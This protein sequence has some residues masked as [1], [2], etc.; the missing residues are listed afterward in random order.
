MKRIIQYFAAALITIY[1]TAAQADYT[2]IVPQKPGGGTSVWATII[3]RELEKHLGEKIIIQH[4]PGAKDIPGIE[5]FHKELR[6]DPKTI[7][8]AHGGNAESYLYDPVEF[9]YRQWAPI[10][11]MNLDIVVG[12]K[13]DSDVYKEVRFAAG[14]GNNPDMMAITLLICGPQRDIAAYLDCYNQKAR[15]IPNM[16]G[17]ERR[18][19]FLRGELNVTRETTAAYFKFVRPLITEGKAETWFAHGVLDLSTGKIVEDPN[20]KGLSFEQVYEKKWGKKPSGELYEAYLLAKS[21]RDVLQKSLWVDKNNPNKEKLQKAL[22]AMLADPAAV[23]AI[24]ADS[25]KYEWF[26]GEQVETAMNQLRAMT[27]EPALKTLVT[28]IKQAFRQEAVYKP[29]L[30]QK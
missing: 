27:T 26:V 17:G 9:D 10:G 15:Y 24:E 2:M 6:F 23:A 8:V 11:L 4:I 1:A 14:S 7:M 13:T 19:A 28:W 25:G 20:F 16:D 30:V 29:N 18:M 21:Y 22:R 12:R 3:A 5:K